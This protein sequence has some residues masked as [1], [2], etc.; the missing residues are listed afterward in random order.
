MDHVL[1][2]C[3]CRHRP[4]LYSRLH[5][6]SLPSPV[7]AGA[8]ARNGL[9]PACSPRH[10]DC[11][12]G[13]FRSPLRALENVR[14]LAQGARRTCIV[15]RDFLRLHGPPQLFPLNLPPHPPPAIPRP[16]PPHTP[17]QKT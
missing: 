13:L 4:L 6:S 3:L 14:T 16:I 9:A 15:A 8:P 12:S 11:G 7:A 2:L 17:P 5:H 1:P 10:S